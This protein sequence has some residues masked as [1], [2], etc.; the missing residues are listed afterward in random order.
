MPRQEWILSSDY[1]ENLLGAHDE[2]DDFNCSIPP[3]VGCRDIIGWLCFSLLVEKIWSFPCCQRRNHLLG[4]V[5]TN[6]IR[7]ASIF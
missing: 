3:H 6:S 2:F 5:F 4:I 1:F 7:F